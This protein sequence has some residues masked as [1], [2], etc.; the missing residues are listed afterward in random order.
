MKKI[1]FLLVL[2]ILSVGISFAQT[3][4]RVGVTAGLNV[5]KFNASGE[6][7]PS[8]DFKAGFQAGV[9]ADFGITDK[10]SIMPE[11]LFAQ[12]GT[13][14]SELIDDDVTGSFSMTLN[15]LQLPINAAYKF[16]VGNGS[17]LFV[18]AGPYFGY[19]V[20]ASGKIT[21]KSQGVEVGVP[22][23]VKFGSNPDNAND[24]DMAVYLKSFDVGVNVGV[25]YEYEKIFCKLQYNHGFSNLLNDS[26]SAS[27]KNMNIAVSVGYY[28][29]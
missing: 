22:F 24:E 21:G 9:V 15:Y 10:F 4:T 17:K 2:S 6:G 27:M 19:G 1:L 14:Y 12:R 23:T 13:K 20:S 5:S 8:F 7:A 18:F 26:G 29:F 28:F 11:L 25:G 3:K 16:D